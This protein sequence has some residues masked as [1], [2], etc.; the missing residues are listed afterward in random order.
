[1]SRKD[2]NQIAFGIVQKATEEA[3][4]DMR[5]DYQKAAAEA[6]RKG[7]LKG[8]VARKKALTAIQRSRIAKKAAR[9]RWSKS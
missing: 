9:A 2:L 6:G 1:M 7:G 3:P 8:G 4:P 5:T